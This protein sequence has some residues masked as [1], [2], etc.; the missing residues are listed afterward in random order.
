MAAVS[1]YQQSLNRMSQQKKATFNPDRPL[2][3]DQPDRLGFKAIASSLASSLV[4]GS[5]SQGLV[6]AIEGSWGSG[7]S[8]MVNL[9]CDAVKPDQ[10]TIIRFDPWLIGDRNAMVSS[11]INDI[12]SKIDALQAKDGISSAEAKEE[13]KGLAKKLRNYSV[14]AGAVVSP[15]A[16]VSASILA[17]QAGADATKAAFDTLAQ[18]GEEKDKPL[19]DL[20]DDL[21][22]GLLELG[23]KFIV[24]ID[25]LDRL[26]PQEANEV[27]RL[28]RAV[29]DFPNIIYLLCYDKEVLAKSLK[30]ALDI[31]DGKQFLQKIVQVH[32]SLPRPEEFDLR[33]WLYE[34][35]YNIIL[36]AGAGVSEPEKLGDRLYAACDIQGKN[37][38]TP[39]EVALIINSLKL[40]LPTIAAKVDLVDLCWLHILKVANEKLY[41]WIERYL[42]IFAVVYN[43]T[44]QTSDHEDLIQEL[45]EI[46]QLNLEEKDTLYEA[47]LW[48][49]KDMLPGFD[50]NFANDGTKIELFQTV[51]DDKL[52][53]LEQQKRI[54]SPSHYRI[55]F[56]FDQPQ[57]ALSDVIFSTIIENSNAGKDV[58]T[59]LEDLIG[60]KRPQGGTQYNLFLDRM[61]RHSMAGLSSVETLVQSIG[62]T[63]DQA[64]INDKR[65]LFYGQVYRMG[66]S[67]F[68]SI[69]KTINPQNREKFLQDFF[70]N[71]KSISWAFGKVLGSELL[72][73]G[74]GA[75]HVQVGKQILTENELNAGV[76]IMLERLKGA[77]R[78]KIKDIPMPLSFLHR[79]KVAAGEKDL[80]DWA[81]ETSAADEDFLHVVA[82][83]Q[84]TEYSDKEYKILSLS[85]LGL[86]F[87]AFEAR[88]RLKDIAANSQNSIDKQKAQELL[89]AIERAG[90]SE[91]PEKYKDV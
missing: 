29:G 53:I 81:Q 83:C 49:L 68:Q 17:G 85:D 89:G 46:L 2:K 10:A 47:V 28:V 34:E 58:T 13:I 36:S 9:L 16:I 20:K 69:L 84:N 12:A 3:A 22:K 57:A 27:I 64:C 35:L 38:K 31:D 6:V 67:I 1:P 61:K 88:T 48:D 44:A 45:K 33:N 5:V 71:C 87:N 21:V 66:Y 77:D 62:N 30:T 25:D 86:C 8:S 72:Y 51:G 42:N 60:K 11:L 41:H 76:A 52:A 7:K 80:F 32:F 26:E 37:L 50:I 14:K 18:I 70:R 43:G 75:E 74:R 63:I 39:R 90:W 91:L 15:L 19:S 82:M 24:V 40:Y 73:H 79:W 55:Y 59:I 56:A 4:E 54:G 65:G 23:H 78:A